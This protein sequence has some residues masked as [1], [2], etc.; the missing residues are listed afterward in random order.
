[1]YGTERVSGT[2][3]DPQLRNQK[4]IPFI[5]HGKP[6]RGNCVHDT[7]KIQKFTEFQGNQWVKHTVNSKGR[8]PN[9]TERKKCPR[10]D[11]LVTHKRTLF[12]AP[13]VV[14]PSAC[15]EIDAHGVY[16]ALWESSFYCYR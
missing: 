9:H 16:W 5:S 12:N 11:P 10:K 14:D 6:D 13:V 4:K 7:V 3:F 1:M 15:S 8:P 2:E